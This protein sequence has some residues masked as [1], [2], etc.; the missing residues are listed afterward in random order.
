MFTKYSHRLVISILICAMGI[1]PVWGRS[2]GR[3]LPA[4]ST[5]SSPTQPMPWLVT[6][7]HEVSVN[8]LVANWQAQGVPVSALEGLPA[9]QRIT[10]VAS[11]LVI[12]PS[13]RIVTRLA[14]FRIQPKPDS[15]TIITSDG[16][17]L[18]PTS[19]SYDAASG[20]SLLVVEGL[21][22]DLP[23]FAASVAA[24]G[25]DHDLRF[26]FPM[27]ERKVEGTLQRDSVALGRIGQ[28]ESSAAGVRVVEMEGRVFSGKA[29]A[30]SFGLSDVLHIRWKASSAPP[31]SVVLNGQGQVVGIVE[32][33]WPTHG[34]V[35]TI[36]EI[37]Q[38]TSRLM[39][40]NRPRRGWIG[41]RL[42][43]R[44]DVA[45]ALPAGG[46]A[47]IVI[48]EVLAGSPAAQAQLQPGDQ[49]RRIN[50]REVRSIAE[51]ARLVAESAIGSE[52][53]LD[54]VR[55]GEH[56]TVPVRVEARPETGVGLGPSLPMMDSV[57]LPNKVSRSDNERLA[58][59]GLVV[60]PL[61][62]AMR[63]ALGVESKGGVLVT[64]VTMSSVVGQAGI[65][66]GDVI[67]AVNNKP[68]ANEH[69]LLSLMRQ[70]RKT[71][72]VILSVIR[73]RK[74]ITIALDPSKLSKPG[75]R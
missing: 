63:R 24:R 74:S 6:V 30:D 12:E 25:T 14:D 58:R 68:V 70:A 66:A 52:I 27:P 67:M 5:R 57:V 7:I 48:G 2:Q 19:V 72:S 44:P 38:I 32:S 36:Q 26:V 31:G 15:I 46:D 71:G 51:F 1:M 62:A 42:A 16:H 23:P 69:T 35:K 55:A 29:E 8:E 73:H 37:R 54:V 18:K 28:S 43:Q 60:Q 22:S 59:L 75:S 3:D 21:K 61:S 33:A 13:G 64:E 53:M 65:R 17:R 50:G 40:Q 4:A 56:R 49:V 34:M 20:Y 41:V 47:A 9:D 11:G 45:V 39:D 10:N